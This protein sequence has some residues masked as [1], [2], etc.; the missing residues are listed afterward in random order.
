MIQ[1]GIG[2]DA[3]RLD[4]FNPADASGSRVVE[5]FRFAD[6]TSLSYDQL[7][8]LGIAVDGTAASESLTG[9]SVRD[10]LRGAGG[11]D[12]LTGGEGDDTYLFNAGEGVVTID[13][14]AS[15]IDPNTLVFGSGIS[16]ADLKLGLMRW[17]ASS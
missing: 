12:Q 16:P 6:G 11:N 13:D 9:S 15:P 2:G 3:I 1:V 7:L 4:G 5:T 14:I 17:P 8:G 10:R